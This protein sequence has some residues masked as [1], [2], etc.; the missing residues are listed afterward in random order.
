MG[1]YI[2]NGKVGKMCN[3]QIRKKCAKVEELKGKCANNQDKHWQICNKSGKLKNEET[4]RTTQK[5]KL[6]KK[7]KKFANM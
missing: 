5:E 3:N 1:R 4:I 6:E 7:G 2:E